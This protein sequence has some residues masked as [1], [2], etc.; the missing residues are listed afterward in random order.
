MTSLEQDSEIVLTED[1]GLTK[2]ILLAAPEDAESPEKD[3]QVT[4]HY[5]GRLLD[6]SK[7]DSSVDRDEPFKFKLGVGSNLF[8]S[9]SFFFSRE[10]P[11]FHFSACSQ[12]R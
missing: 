5:T 8:F 12:G 10:Q 6:G 1:G 7:F 9:F 4:V 11:F 3:D 2:K